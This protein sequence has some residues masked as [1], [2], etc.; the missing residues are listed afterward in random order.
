[1]F[2]VSLINWDHKLGYQCI[3][4]ILKSDKADQSQDILYAALKEANQVGDRVCA[5]STLRALREGFSAGHELSSNITPILRCAV[6]ILHS[7]DDEEKKAEDVDEFSKS[8]DIPTELCSTFQAGKFL[9]GLY[10][11]HR[12]CANR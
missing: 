10:N 3:Q 4:N 1:M 12:L 5:L 6:R 7:L 2:R 8:L 9:L 11:H